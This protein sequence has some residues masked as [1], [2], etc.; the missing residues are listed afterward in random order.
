MNLQGEVRYRDKDFIVG[1]GTIITYDTCIPLHAVSAI[2]IKDKERLPMTWGIV[3]IVVGILLLVLPL[4]SFIGGILIVCGIILI[5]IRSWIN[6]MQKYALV[7]QVHA[8]G[9]YI[10]EH[11]DLGFIRKI[12]DIIR[13]ALDDGASITYINMRSTSVKQNFEGGSTFYSFGKNNSFG[14]VITGNDNTVEGGVRNTI[15]SNNTTNNTTMIFTADEWNKLESYFRKRGEE[16]G[17]DHQAY[18]AC[19]EL[20]TYARNKDAKGMRTFLKSVGKG[21]V[22]AVL[23]KATESGLAEIFHR[24]A[25]FKI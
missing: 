14:H 9:L 24:L 16:L 17:K 15:N 1:N 13:Q 22:T 6:S 4:V 8:G 23:A 18:A 10:F 5:A 21:V 20:E 2:K 25:T 19:K 7:I 11:A 3:M 12:A